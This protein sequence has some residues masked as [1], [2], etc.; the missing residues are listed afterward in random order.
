MGLKADK[1]LIIIINYFHCGG[2]KGNENEI[3]LFKS[4]GS[5]RYWYYWNKSS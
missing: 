5:F 2:N 1:E 3:K 4:Y